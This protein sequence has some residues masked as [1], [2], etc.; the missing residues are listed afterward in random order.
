MDDTSD[1]Q[2]PVHETGSVRQGA[3]KN[4]FYNILGTIIAKT[5]SLVFT[6]ILARLLLPELF[7]IY[8]LVLSLAMIAITFTDL[9][10]SRALVRY[11]SEALGKGQRTKARGYI[12]YLFKARISLVIIVIFLI[13]IFGKFISNN[14]FD[15]PEVFLPLLFSGFY[16]FMRSFEGLIRNIFVITKELQKT[17]FMQTTLQIF[18][19]IFTILAILIISDERFVVSGIFV[20]LSIAVF[21]S[22]ITGLFFLKKDKDL[23]IG[24]KYSEKD[25]KEKVETGR[26]WNYIGLASV[27]S[28]SLAFFGSIDTLI[29]GSFV[30]AEYI[31][32]YRAALGLVVTI[33]G[34]FSFGAVFLP[35]FTQSKQKQIQDGFNE[36]FRYLVLITIPSVFGVL[37]VAKYFIF[38]VYGSEYII[39]TIPLYALAFLIMITPFIAL[40]SSLFEAKERIGILSKFVVISLLLN[41]ILDF[42]FIL[43]LL[44]FSQELAILGAGIA[45]VI[46]RGFYLL[47]IQTKA[48]T[49]LGIKTPFRVIIKPIISAVLMTLV[50]I[51]FS[52][53]IDMNLFYGIVEIIIGI[54]IYFSCLFLLKG[55]NKQDIDN[56]KILILKKRG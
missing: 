40:Y 47:A 3:V 54:I 19:I 35:I 22:V 8:N 11:T 32:F 51:T 55:I 48:K 52:Y 1:F 31:G 49:S 38:A 20:A 18:R 43:Y 6:I 4:S 46:S 25:S 12:R 16:I 53:F 24:S 56:L 50:L 33:A 36:A 37:V 15:K 26:I 2:N 9:G 44:N 41:I 7:G 27:V 39:A 17:T 23:L 13:I 42:I 45:T 30:A 14:I 28:I 29:L 34:L 5:G 10:I 21:F